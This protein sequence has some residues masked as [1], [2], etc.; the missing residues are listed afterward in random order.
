VLFDLRF[1]LIAELAAGAIEELD[2]VVLVG[3]VR[4]ADDHAEIA[5]EPFGEVSDARRRQW[6]DQHHVD[7]GRD[8]ARFQRGFE[9]VA[10]DP[11]VLADQHRAA[12]R[13][14]DAR[15]RTGQF[16]RE[17]HCQRMLTHTATHA[18]GAKVFAAQID[19]LEDD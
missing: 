16:Q 9:H 1:D 15:R 11:R 18:I 8:E 14:Q 12:F 6:T 3:I 17:L 2:A 7:A 13:S 10:G 4:G 5:F 19:A